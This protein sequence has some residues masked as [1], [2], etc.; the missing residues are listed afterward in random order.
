MEITLLYHLLLIYPRWSIT[1]LYQT[2]P[3]YVP[4]M[5]IPLIK[6]SLLIYPD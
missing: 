4:Q 2:G 5:E 1:V 3:S 6:H